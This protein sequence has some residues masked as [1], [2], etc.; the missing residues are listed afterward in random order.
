DSDWI[1]WSRLRLVSRAN[2]FAQVEAGARPLPQGSDPLLVNFDSAQ[3]STSVA[4]DAGDLPDGSPASLKWLRRA[5]EPRQALLVVPSTQAAFPISVR[6]GARL[7][8][9]LSAAQ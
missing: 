7:R 6:P 9:A 5:G 8:F 1:G 3:I 4:W 2:N